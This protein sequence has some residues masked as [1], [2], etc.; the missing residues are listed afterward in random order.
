[1]SCARSAD[2]ACV[3]R[4]LFFTNH[5][6]V[7]ST[8]AERPDLRLRDIARE[9]GIT[10]RAT[11]R[12][13]TDLIEAGYLDRTRVGARSQ[14]TVNAGA[15]LPRA[16]QAKHTVAQ[17]IRLL[18]E[19]G[20]AEN[21]HG[22]SEP[23]SPGG[24]E[25]DVE[26]LR[27][28]FAAA[29]AGMMIAD[30]SGRVLAVNP[31]SC[32]IL[33]RGEEELVGRH[34]RDWAHSEDVA[35]D[36]DSLRQLAGGE[37]S[38]Y[39][40]DRRYL[41]PDGSTKWV[42]FSVATAAHPG[43]GARLFVA[44]VVEIDQRRRQDRALAEAE[45]RFRSVVDNAPIGV[46]LVTPDGRFIKV[47]RALCEI[48]GYGETELLLR[49]FQDITHPEDLDADL[50]FARQMLS[51]EIRTYQMDKRYWH[52]DGH[53]IWIS[54]SVSLV[55][56]SGGGPLYF[57]SQITDISARRAREDSMR[58][59]IDRIAEA[60]SIIDSD[61]TH[62]HVNRASRG[63]LDDL[64]ERFEHEPVA[65]QD[66]GAIAEDGT[67]LPPH[68][69]P[70]EITRLTGEAIDDQ[71]V[72]FPSAT[73]AVRWLRIS[74]R[75]L[76]D[77]PAP[78]QV[79]VSFTDVTGRKHAERALALSEARLHALFRYIPAAM[80][81]RGLDGRYLQVT[82]SV[83]RALGCT[84]EDL[85]GRHPSEHLDPNALAQTLEDDDTMRVAGAAIS[86]ELTVTHADGSEHDYYVVKWP[87]LDHKR[88]VAAFG[89]FSL[90][91]TDRKHAEHRALQLLESAPDGMI[92]TDASGTILIVNAQA[93]TLFGYQRDQLI[94]QNIETLIPELA[95][96]A[97]AAHRAAYTEDPHVHPMG[98]GVELHARR[99]D[100]TEFPVEISLSPIDTAQGP[101]ISAAVRDITHRKAAE[102]A[103]DHSRQELVRSNAEL[104][105]FAPTLSRNVSD[106]LRTIAASA[107]LLATRHGPALSE[108]GAGYAQ[109]I[110]DT[111][112]RLRGLIDDLLAHPLTPAG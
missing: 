85:V 42:R 84:P 82:D 80:S 27:A 64:R 28:M 88:N 40:R 62:L 78:Y 3:A 30:A 17:A 21:G 94:G 106:P 98:E 104:E 81:L 25:D 101:L 96:R 13:I 7:L 83:A 107:E 65:D 51:G 19:P 61:G 97:H 33:E 71:V 77:G 74:T 14:Y 34:L 29:P 50:E 69:L 60:V 48:T 45:E 18:N 20:T 90:D 73:E 57:I 37:R 93:E 68:Q 32:R 24:G 105:R 9:V 72:G 100:G 76:S 53:L 16:R 1:M 26:M 2:R 35:A 47:N 8:L 95:R 10:E 112:L 4:S 63:I 46:A 75:R 92:I 44:H 103:L 22:A 59:V 67:P 36:E 111:S 110:L 109:H 11:Q 91:I 23:N 56:D 5:L 89:A 58:R 49:T 79:I 31:A 38:E 54:L 43:T 12:I 39:A 41:L 55:R 102:H 66:W 6:Q 70:V 108:Q 86:R 52:A 15:P 87:V 99:R